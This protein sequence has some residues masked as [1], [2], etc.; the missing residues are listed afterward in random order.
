MKAPILYKP[1]FDDDL[2]DIDCSAALPPGVTLTSVGEITCTP[3]TDPPLTFA[4]PVIS[5][6]DITYSD[7]VAPAGTVIQ[8][9]IAGGYVPTTAGGSYGNT[10]Y[11]VIARATRSDGRAFSAPVRLILKDAP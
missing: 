11:L 3:V 8:V 6:A 5:T 1:S 4:N 2:F 9:D 7:H 10:E